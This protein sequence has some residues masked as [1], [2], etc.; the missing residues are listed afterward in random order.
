MNK[1]NFKAYL[2][3]VSICIIWG[4]TYLAI[5]VGVKDMPPLLFAGMRWIIAGPIFLLVLKLRG[6]KLPDK[7]DLKHIAV[8]GILLLGLGNGLVAFAE[9]WL[10]SG[11]T[12]LLLTTMP[13]WV[14]GI[15]SALPSGPKLN[16]MIIFGL[17]L[18]ISGVFFILGID[19]QSLL[20]SS[21][22]I[23]II[24]LMI[25]ELGW[26][27][28]TVY[29]KYVKVTVHPLMNAAVQM[30][31]AGLALTIVSGL[32][33]EYPRFHFTHDSFFAFLYLLVFGA[34]IAYGAYIYA[35]NHLPIS[36]VSTYAY[37]N[38]VIALF[39]GWLI[40]D[41]KLNTAIIIGALIILLAVYIVKKGSNKQIK[42]R[43]V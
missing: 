7:K 42:I 3:W 26:A 31:I 35:I 19:F 32:I 22:L 18:G 43:G 14:V 16:F 9:Q 39:L 28:G 10:P 21:Y 23:G 15:E 36:F 2:A 37:I 4:T 40:L 11:L 13:F 12:A 6:Y 5:R 30:C 24:G 8:V 38:P 33:G 29:S 34:F 41:E 1:D 20:D 25:G 17:V 27:S